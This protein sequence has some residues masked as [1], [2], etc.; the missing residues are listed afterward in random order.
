[1]LHLQDWADY[2]GKQNAEMCSFY[3]REY[4]PSG[5]VNKMICIHLFCVPYSTSKII[6]MFQVLQPRKEN[7]DKNAWWE[8]QKGFLY[9]IIFLLNSCRCCCLLHLLDSIP[10]PKTDV[11][12][13]H[14][15]WRVDWGTSAGSACSIHGL[16]WFGGWWGIFIDIEIIQYS[17]L[18]VY[19]TTSI[20]FSTQ[21]STQFYQKDSDEVSMTCHGTFGSIRLNI[22]VL[23]KV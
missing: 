20:P 18:Q 17:S 16:R 3:R 19:S 1:M 22:L 15:V 4:V 14:P 9:F 2:E 12:G 10:Q 6:L 23:N 11:C 13:G 8:D 21:F 7:C 5:K